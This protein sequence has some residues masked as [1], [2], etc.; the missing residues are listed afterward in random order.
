MLYFTQT[1]LIRARMYKR[2]RGQTEQLAIIIGTYCIVCGCLVLKVRDNEL[3]VV[4]AP[5]EDVTPVGQVVRDHGQ[6]VPG[7]EM[8]NKYSKYINLW[9]VYL[10]HLQ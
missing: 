3:V 1:K 6:S 7:E 5:G 2:R 8:L 9:L 4:L 10:S